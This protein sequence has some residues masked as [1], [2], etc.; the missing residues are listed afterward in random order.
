MLLLAVPVVVPAPF[1]G[2]TGEGRL[3]V[4]ALSFV[5][6]LLTSLSRRPALS[7]AP[8]RLPAALLGGLAVLGLAQLV[9]L[10]HWLLRLVSPRAFEIYREAGETASTLG[11][12]APLAPRLSISPA[13]TWHVV[14]LVLA[15]AALLVSSFV[16]L[17]FRARRRAFYAALIV[18][19][20]FHVLRAVA[21]QPETGRLSG[22]FVNPNH[23]AGWLEIALPAALAVLVL[24][25]TVHLTT[26]RK[27]GST[28]L[29]EKRIVAV[30]GAVLL[31]GTL[32]T[33]IGLT[34]S[35]GG[36]LAALVVTAFLVA[37]FFL[38]P[39]HVPH[40]HGPARTSWLA[41]HG[42]SVATFSAAVLF[43]AT[44]SGSAPLLRF[45]ATDPRDLDSDSRLQLWRL[46]IKAWK[47]FPVFG[48]GLGS[49]LE[50][51]RPLQPSEMSGFVEW[52][53]SDPLQLLVTG[54]VVGLLLAFGGV[55]GPLPA[56]RPQ[57]P[58]AAPTTSP[59]PSPRGPRRAPFA[60]PSRLR[61][62][63][64]LAARHPGHARLRRRRLARRHRL[65]AP[66]RGGRGRRG[67][68]RDNPRRA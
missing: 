29:L 40:Q 43:A 65:E 15:C 62:V 3:V 9:P 50:A 7:Y 66:R 41:T 22:P 44:A 10:P 2:I 54:G 33:G 68:R 39:A 31:W 37:L 60:R 58:G 21:T 45:I 56:P 67:W 28:D 25:A 18:A 1:G 11:G 35:R 4:Q 48:A 64:P 52:A 49:F 42:S 47:E 59:G 24:V 14:L 16:L 17:R 30:A 26:R 12:P 55:R 6:A 53:D 23:F 51:F 20:V 27:R 32:A 19:A 63:Q 13:E 38:F 5:I 34:R 57:P 61:R 8:V 46:S 36:L